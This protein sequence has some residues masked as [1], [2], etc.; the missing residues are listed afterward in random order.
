MEEL[1]NECLTCR[2]CP[3]CEQRTNVVF[4]CGNPAAEVMFIG[5]GPGADE[6][7]QGEPFVGKA[8]Q[9]LNDMLELIDLQR[10]Q[11][12]IA[13]MVKCRPPR[14]RD[15]L[16][17]EKAACRHWLDAQLYLVNPK[18]IVC[19]G[20]IAACAFIDPEF[21]ITQ[22]HGKWYTVNDTLIMALYH[23]AALLRD[24]SK[25][26]ETVADLLS[27][28]EMIGKKTSLYQGSEKLS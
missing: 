19:L 25:G 10:E 6:D 1:R 8:G 17:E 15:P 16:N 20:R 4:G 13:N 12:Y 3:L 18:I 28:R 27:L 7:E 22:Q 14:N 26:P 9:L 11:V 21:K 2:Q 5:E 24:M 23:P